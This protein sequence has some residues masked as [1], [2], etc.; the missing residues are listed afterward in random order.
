MIAGVVLAL[1]L[2]GA[3]APVIGYTNPFLLAGSEWNI[4]SSVADASQN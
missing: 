2:G 4:Q 1:I 3:T